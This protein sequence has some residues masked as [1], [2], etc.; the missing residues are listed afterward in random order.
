MTI[1][2]EEKPVFGSSISALFRPV[3][4]YERWLDNSPR[5][6]AREMALAP[7]D[8]FLLV[9]LA[10][11]LP[12]PPLVVD[13]V[14][15][16]TRGASAI[17]WQANLDKLHA[18]QII[19]ASEAEERRFLEAVTHL[20]L[21]NDGRLAEHQPALSAVPPDT[22]TPVLVVTTATDA[23]IAMAWVE[24]STAPICVAV[25]DVGRTG[26]A[27]ELERLLQIAGTATAYR[28][29]LM[30]ELAPALAGSR[31]AIIQ[32]RSCLEAQTRL[33]RI[34]WM[35]QGNFDFLRLADENVRLHAKIAAQQS[36]AVRQRQQIDELTRNGTLGLASRLTAL[37][38]KVVPRTL[39]IQASKMRQARK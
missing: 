6:G 17:L 35:F 1:R 5:P 28:L 27:P 14:S 19:S 4:L 9:Q 32:R 7:I 10:I 36:A 21:S 25:S 30:R 15:P 8:A 18:V 2:I 3:D 11:L 34:A 39:R 24:Q 12:R 37:Y 22:N 31:L 33:E 23:P 38:R 16:K 29:S 20:E 13:F 26:D